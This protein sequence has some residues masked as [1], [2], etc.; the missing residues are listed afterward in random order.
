M[1]AYD[2]VAPHLIA[3]GAKED[4]VAATAGGV[5]ESLVSK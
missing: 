1:H 2:R 4:V 3:L 5:Y